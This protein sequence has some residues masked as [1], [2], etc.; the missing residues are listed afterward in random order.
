M[1]MSKYVISLG[2]N[3]LGHDA[4]SQKELLKH[5]SQAILPL[6]KEN[7]DIVIVHGN[8]P[9]VGMINLAFNESTSTPMMPFAECGAMSQGYIGF[10]IQNAIRN[11]LMKSNIKREVTTLV[12]QV[13]VDQ[14]DP[15]FLNPTKPIGSFYKE[16]EAKTLEKEL[17]YQM[18]EDAG[19][20]YRR[21]IASPKPIDVIEK[22]SL[23]TLL[24]QHHIVIAG[25]G[26]GI[27]VIENEYGY[28]GIDAVIDKD[29]ASAKIAEIINADA[30]IILT[31]VDHVY[32]NFNKPNQKKLEKI[33]VDALDRLIKEDHFKKGSMLP[34]VEACLSFVKASG[35]KAIIA[36]LDQAYDA[37]V[38][39]RGTE[40][41][42][43]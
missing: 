30:L 27:P 19:R 16:I 4:K 25:G 11:Q 21:V 13:L 32:I 10:H 38:H 39:H 2:G 40:I 33:T 1:T 34:K 23:L 35:H 26:G 17:G 15:G 18:V 36:S 3:A 9:Q 41:L 29:F 12:T 7:H 6:I 24:N 31:A 8:G 14:H 37:I 28:E 22:Q 20:G 42:P 43:N 5:V